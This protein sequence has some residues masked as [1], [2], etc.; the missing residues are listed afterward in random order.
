MKHILA[1]VAIAAIMTS[2]HVKPRHTVSLD[3]DWRTELGKV[4]LP[5]TTDEAGLGDT[6]ADLG[7]D[8]RLARRHSLCRPL[9]YTGEI[10]IPASMDGKHIE[11]FIE[12]TKPT[13]LWIDGD[14]IG[15]Q[16]HLQT[17]HTYNISGYRAGRHT[18]RLRIDNSW[19]DGTGEGGL[20]PQIGGSHAATDATQTNWNG[21]V[22]EISLRST[23]LTYIAHVSTTTSIDTASVRRDDEGVLRAD[24]ASLRIDLEIVASKEARVSIDAKCVPHPMSAGASIANTATT[25]QVNLKKGS[26]KATIEIDMDGV[27]LWSEWQPALYDVDITL[28]SP[29]GVDKTRETI[30]FRTFQTRGTQFAVNGE[31]TFL[32]G[33]HDACVFPLTGYAPMDKK[34]WDKVFATAKEY[35]VNHY[36]FH[37]WCPPEAA[38]EA[39]DEAGIYLQPELPYWGEMKPSGE[40]DATRRLNNFLADEA[41]RIVRQYGNHPSFV[42]M[43]LGNELG[44]DTTVMRQMI[45]YLRKADPRHLYAAGSNNFLGWMGTVA[46]EDFY[47]SCRTGWSQSPY[48]AHLRASFSLADAEDLGILNGTYPN[49][50]T[51]FAKAAAKIK[52]PIVGHETGQYQVYP[53]FAEIKKYTGVLRPLSLENFRASLGRT[54]T[55]MDVDSLSAV[56]S[57]ASGALSALCYKADIEMN[58]RTPGFGG[59]QLL[60]LQDYPGQGGALVGMLDAFMD[61]KGIV[62]PEEWRGFCSSLVPLALMDKYT[63]TTAEGFK[64]DVAVANYTETHIAGDTL[65]WSITTAAGKEVACG[66]FKAASAAGKVTTTGSIVAKL[67]SIDKPTQLKL[68]LCLGK[69]TNSYSIWA[70][71][72]KNAGAAD[73]GL[74]KSSTLTPAILAKVEKGATLLLTPDHNK[75]EKQTVGGMFIPDYWNYAM[76]KTISENNGKPVSA[77]TLGYLIDSGKPLF[78]AFPTESH[79]DFQWWDIMKNSRPLILDGTPP[80]LWP[81]VAAIDNVNRNHKLGVVFGMRIGQGKVLVCMTDLDAVRSH[82]EGRQWARAIEAYAASEGFNPAYTGTAAELRDLLTRDIED[83]RIEGVKNLSDYKEKK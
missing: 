32:R 34:S 51:T 72:D 23:P 40:G 67:N 71:P 66:A 76:F 11:L 37:S 46:G 70:Y 29:D 24:T 27:A 1:A 74:I 39:A 59:F 18:V 79:A 60:D 6:I 63:F 49:T 56:L 16:T 44:G 45:D 75:V 80:A 7:E 2:C 33:K 83:A 58:L 36:R 38:F 81:E 68:T 82:P 26:N 3:G 4:H 21:A 8:S 14:S 19:Q 10:I 64:A 47:V 41:L 25:T 9:T 5:G 35:G 54:Y 77:G 61:S 55:G 69:A 20:P 12:R 31:T 62:T 13:T 42:M 73:K 22:G 52:V 78:D 28:D 57:K 53:D 17:P 48:G 30:G 15:S 43:S 65:R 50:R